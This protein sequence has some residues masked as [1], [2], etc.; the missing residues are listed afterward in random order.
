MLH[1]AGL[2]PHLW[3]GAASVCDGVRDIVAILDALPPESGFESAL[4]VVLRTLPR[5]EIVEACQ[6]LRCSNFSTQRVAWLTT[7][8]DDLVQPKDLTLADLK[9]LMANTAFDDL[10]ALLTAT[11]KAAS[12]DMAPVEEISARVRDIPPEEVAPPPLLTGH[13][14][15]ALRLPQGPKYKQILDAVYYAQLNGSVV[16]HAA[17]LEMAR[18]LGAGEH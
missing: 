13:D 9:L 12:A 4:A 6:A 3:P 11:R 18:R 16:D 2:L 1:E 7:H 10:L 15:A 8:Q 17:A 5:A 14:L